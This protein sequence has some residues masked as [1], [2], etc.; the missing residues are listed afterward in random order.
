MDDQ[1]IREKIVSKRSRSIVNIHQTE[2]ATGKKS[3]DE[4]KKQV[5]ERHHPQLSIARNSSE[6]G[7]KRK[8]LVLDDIRPEYEEP[9]SPEV[10]KNRPN[11]LGNK[12]P[13]I[14]GTEQSSSNIKKIANGALVIETR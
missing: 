11:E 13:S 8:R 5:Q 14:D 6:T 10:R 7:G 12:L 2:E 4:R 3:R 9:K 1:S